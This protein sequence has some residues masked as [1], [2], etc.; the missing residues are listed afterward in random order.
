M[1]VTLT[2]N[3]CASSQKTILTV[4]Y[5]FATSFTR[6]KEKKGNKKDSYDCQLKTSTPS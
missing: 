3:L 6:I 5:L 4:L 1:R 2:L